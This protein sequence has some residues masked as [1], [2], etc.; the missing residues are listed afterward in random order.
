MKK[1]ELRQIIREEIQT[2]NEREIISIEK[3][4]DMRKSGYWIIVSR[5]L[6]KVIAVD[7]NEKKMMNLFKQNSDSM[8]IFSPLKTVKI[9]A[10]QQR[11]YHKLHDLI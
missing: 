7:K 11:E 1:S 6:K 5:D 9:S 3:A 8:K 2:L 10:K 4:Q